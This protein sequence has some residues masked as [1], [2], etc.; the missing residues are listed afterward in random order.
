MKPYPVL[1]AL[2]RPGAVLLLCLLGGFVVTALVAGAETLNVPTPAAVTPSYHAGDDPQVKLA[3][4]DFYNLEYDKA[5]S[6]FQRIEKAHPE[7]L[8]AIVHV[9]QVTVFRE[10]YRLNLLDTTLY[11]H[12]GFLSGKAVNGNSAV[13]AQV[14]QLTIRAVKLCDG[15]LAKDANDVKALYVRSVARGFMPNG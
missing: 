6:Q 4:D 11:A 10:L 14:D 5:M 8:F 9:L 1:N 13:R 12:D 15:R 7:D 3:L 2:V